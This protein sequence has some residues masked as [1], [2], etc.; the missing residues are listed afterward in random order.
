MIR[1]P[2]AALAAAATALALSAPAHA[3][4]HIVSFDDLPSTVGQFWYVMP[5]GYGG[6][7]WKSGNWDYLICS[8]TWPCPQAGPDP[9]PYTPHTY[10]GFATVDSDIS[11]DMKFGFTGGPAV[12]NGAWVTTFD[13]DYFGY[14]LMYQGAQAWTTGKMPCDAAPSFAASGHSG[15]VDEVDIIASDIRDWAIDDLSFT[16]AAV[17]EPAS[18]VLLL[19]GLMTLSLAGLAARRRR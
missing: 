16:T 5:T 9:Y 17:P 8:A 1:S 7:D 13:G 4:T 12:F 3:A 15:L 2:S 14:T 18:P 11:H 6:I 10:P 19:A